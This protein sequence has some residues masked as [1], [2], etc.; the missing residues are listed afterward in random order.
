MRR[1][2][3][4]LALAAAGLLLGAPLAQA[5]TQ[6]SPPKPAAAQPDAAFEAQKAA[7]LALPPATRVA[8][9]D[10]LVWLGLYNG[11]SD[12]DFGKRTRDAI[13][14]FQTGQKAPGD[15]VLSAGQLQALLA[16]ANKARTAAG[17][18]TIAD[19]R[20]GARIGAPTKLLGAKSG[21]TLDLAS[22]PGGDLS[23]LYARLSAETPT[24][25]VAYKAIKP[26]AFFV[27]SGQDAG[28]TFY[29]RYELNSAATPPIRG[30]T[31]SYPVA[32]GDLFRVALAVADAFVAFPPQGAATASPASAMPAQ[33]PAAPP[34]PSQPRA[35]ALIVAPDRALTALKP[36]D[37][38]N[39]SVGGKPARFARTDPATGLALLSGD[40]AAEAKAPPLGALAPDLVVLS[41]DGGRVAAVPAALQGGARTTVV[42]S[43]GK[44]AAGGPVFDRQGGLAGLVA[45][46]AEEPKRVGGVALAGPHGLIDAE[47]VGAFL[48]GGA[49]TPIAAPTALSAGAIAEREKTAVAAVM[50]GKSLA[51][52]FPT[53]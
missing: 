50:C 3:F 30:F 46:I 47:A 6:T 49:L 28:R 23:D 1:T 53:P 27:V 12:G 18:Q 10:A 52:G 7:F 21:V 8:A 17:F 11:T 41:A 31:F 37:C 13:V 40:F 19:P 15:G 48:G 44:S 25:K 36:E 39:P 32:R 42:A 22:D 34:P 14:A 43:L 5:Q 29:T 51:V 35:T 16:A 45:P 20:T 24:R 9:Q 4:R 2:P 33:T 26:G 38:P